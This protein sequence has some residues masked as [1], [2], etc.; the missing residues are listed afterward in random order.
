MGEQHY[1]G[2]RFGDHS[3]GS[4]TSRSGPA[5]SWPPTRSARK[6]RRIRR[7]ILGLLRR[8]VVFARDEANLLLFPPLRAG[9]SPK[10]RRPWSVGGDHGPFPPEPGRFLMRQRILRLRCRNLL[11]TVDF[12]PK[13]QLAGVVMPCR[14]TE[15]VV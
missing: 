6:K 12:A 10:G 14:N 3:E 8:S 4:A 15:G 7:H 5:V 13:P 11:R 9:W 1:S 2:T